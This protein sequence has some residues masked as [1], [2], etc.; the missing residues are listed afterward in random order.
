MLKSVHALMVLSMH[1]FSN[2]ILSFTFDSTGVPP[3]GFTFRNDRKHSLA[4]ASLAQPAAPINHYT[5]YHHGG[6]VHYP[7]NDR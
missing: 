4:A 7:G 5:D 2:Y 6:F 1:A 3:H